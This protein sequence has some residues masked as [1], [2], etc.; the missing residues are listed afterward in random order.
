MENEL[1][2]AEAVK[3]KGN[4]NGNG[5]TNDQLQDMKGQLDAI[6]QALFHQL[7]GYALLE[8]AVDLFYEKI[9]SDGRI[10]YFFGSN[11]TRMQH[12]QMKSFLA[13]T[14]GVAALYGNFEIDL[15]PSPLNRHGMTTDHFVIAVNHL[16]QSFLDLGVEAA[17]VDKAMVYIITSSKENSN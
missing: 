16:T 17:L 13:K 14:F 3:T 2:T 10:N 1:Q 11:D 15:D 4:G 12:A 8:E 5:H 6:N 7:G 9:L